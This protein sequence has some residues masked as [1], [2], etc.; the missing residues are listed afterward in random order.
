M[1]RAHCEAPA[2]IHRSSP[3][4]RFGRLPALILLAWSLAAVAPA[5]ARSEEWCSEPICA[6]L[7]GSDVI[8]ILAPGSFEI[9]TSKREGL[10]GELY[11]LQTDPDRLHDLSNALVENGIIWTKFKEQENSTTYVANRATDLELLEPGG[12]RVRLSISGQHQGGS[13]EVPWEDLGYQQTFTIYA[14]GEIYVDYAFL[15][16]RDIDVDSFQLILKT[17]G[18]WAPTAEASAPG[19]AHCVGEHGLDPPYGATESSLAMMTS[20]GIQYYADLLMAMYV[21]RFRHSYWNEGYPGHDYRCAL[22]LTTGGQ[23]SLMPMGTSHLALMVRLALDMNDPATAKKHADAY[24][25]PDPD[26]D[27][28]QGLQVLTDPGDRDADGFNEEEGTYGLQRQAAQDV[29][30]TYHASLPRANPAFKILDWNEEVPQTISLN[31]AVVP[32]GAQYRASLLDTTLI[33]QLLGERTSDVQVLLPG[34]AIQVPAMTRVGA[35]LLI[36]AILGFGARRLSRV[37]SEPG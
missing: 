5:P 4:A 30:F 25:N 17:T 26:L 20:D 18:D 11:D 1:K 33:L 3:R 24:R 19:E 37:A 13:P 7:E 29:A 35:T 28:I 10:G 15:A 27:V 2:P 22:Y 32:Q 23:Y 8:R 16:A 31:G 12:I 36:V 34:P 9:T 6:R 14:T 21:G